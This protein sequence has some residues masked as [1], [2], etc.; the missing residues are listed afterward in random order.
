MTLGPAPLIL[1]LASLQLPLAASHSP[2]D[3]SD[4]LLRA[5]T[6]GTSLGECEI[7]RPAE[8]S[9]ADAEFLAGA[10]ADLS[11]VLTDRLGPVHPH[12]FQLVFAADREQFAEWTGR[13]MPE[14]IQALAME[15]P[16]R[17]VISGFPGPLDDASRKE[18]E[19]ILLHELTHA[20]LH[21][22]RWPARQTSLPAWLH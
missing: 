2:S 20:Y 22:A 19:E 18:L 1:L 6:V 21:R 17:L 15:S 3:T 7:W 8:Y 4:V 12:P 10:A 14:W 13:S 16:P 11:Q 9:S 5:G